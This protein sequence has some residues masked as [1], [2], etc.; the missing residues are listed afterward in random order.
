M[1][2]ALRS[3]A[4]IGLA[5]VLWFFSM[6]LSSGETEFFSARFGL[7]LVAGAIGGLWAVARLRSETKMPLFMYL[8][9]PLFIVAV[10]CTAKWVVV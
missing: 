8:L 3:P 6:F 5:I 9:G 7:L 1:E 4:V 2:Q 10:G